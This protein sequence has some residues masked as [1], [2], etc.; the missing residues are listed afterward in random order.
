VQALIMDFELLN[1]DLGAQQMVEMLDLAAP[2][3][4]RHSQ[5][6]ATQLLG[7]RGKGLAPD[8]EGL[9][10][11]LE[12]ARPCRLTPRSP[13]LMSAS[14]PVL[15]GLGGHGTAV[16]GL[17]QLGQNRLISGSWDG[18]LRV[19]DLESGKCTEKFD[20]ES[21][22]VAMDLQVATGSCVS[23]TLNAGG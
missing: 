18:S 12:S 22:V 3:I 20:V 21:S 7:R 5:Q 19:W 15:R 13:T 2:I 17:V 8:V 4:Q 16:S 1:Q 10:A 11:Q 23:S 14:S 9:V 6:L